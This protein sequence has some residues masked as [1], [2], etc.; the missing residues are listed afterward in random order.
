MK[1]FKTILI[2]PPWPSP[3]G[4]R[5][6]DCKSH[7]SQSFFKVTLDDLLKFPLGDLADIQAHVYI[8]VMNVYKFE[9]TAIEMMAKAGFKFTNRIIWVKTTQA[10]KVSMALGSYYRLSYEQLFFGVKGGLKAGSHSLPNVI[11]APRQGLAVKPD[12]SYEFI[13]SMSPSPRLEVFARRQMPGWEVWGNQ[14]KSTIKIN[15][16]PSIA[17]HDK[18]RFKDEPYWHKGTR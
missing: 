12:K 16:N 4:R 6:V 5:D 1:K 3:S 17:T 2:D 7:D 14:I 8:W 10:G 18:G 15:W 11:M 13:N 9:A